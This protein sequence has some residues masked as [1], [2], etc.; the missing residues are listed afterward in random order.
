MLQT[1]QIVIVMFLWAICFPL[2]KIGLPFA[3]HITFASIRAFIAGMTLLTIALI[4]RRSLPKDWKTWF[5]LTLIGL[6]ATTFG[7]F[8]MFH[9]SEFVSPGIATVISNTQPLMA[10]LLALLVLG[11]YLDKRGKLGML[12]GFLGILLIALPGLLNTSSSNYLV[13]IGYILLSAAGITIS[14]VLIR[15]IAVQVDALTAMGLQLILGSIFLALIALA[16]EDF[17][18]IDW[19]PAFLFSLLGLSLP[20]TA[21][22]YWLWFHVLKKIELN[23]ANVFSF[24]VPI[25]GLIMGIVFYNETYGFM[26]LVGFGLIL[27]GIILVN[28]SQKDR[29]LKLSLFESR[30]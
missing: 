4:L 20:G 17:T 13:G 24:L 22:A 28:W 23:N 27:F 1:L 10:S 21:L 14:N 15:Y 26:A 12:L 25:F 11:E 5:L 19:S 29:A 6:G 2:I 18:A 30:E 7:F 16:T 3:P 9:S 8:G